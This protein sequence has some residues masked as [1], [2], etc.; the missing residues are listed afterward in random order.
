MKPL[1]SSE[2]KRR[3]P[4]VVSN[5]RMPKRGPPPGEKNSHTA[6]ATISAAIVAK[7]IAV[8]SVHAIH[9]KF[10]VTPS[11]AAQGEALGDVVADEIYDERAGDDGEHAR[12]G[13]HAPI[14]ARRR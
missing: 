2:M 10:M 4:R 13:E 3:S 12:R 14:E 1:P 6:I 8:G 11:H 5:R 7:N 9:E